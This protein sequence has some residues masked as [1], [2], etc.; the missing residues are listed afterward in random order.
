MNINTQ[1]QNKISQIIFEEDFK[2]IVT[3]TVNKLNN[4]Y[5]NPNP[6]PDYLDAEFIEF[7]FGQDKM[8]PHDKDTIRPIHYLFLKMSPDLFKKIAKLNLPWNQLT[9]NGSHLLNCMFANP[10]L[11]NITDISEWINTHSIDWVELNRSNWFLDN[12]IK[13]L[14][15]YHVSEQVQLA[16]Y[17]YFYSENKD[18]LDRSIGLMVCYSHSSVVARAIADGANL[19]QT[20]GVLNNSLLHL[21]FFKEKI[22]END[23]KIADMLIDSGLGLN[24]NNLNKY[25]PFEYL[26]ANNNSKWILHFLRKGGDPNV[27]CESDGNILVTFIKQKCSIETFKELVKLGCNYKYVDDHNFSLLHWATYLDLLDHIKYLFSLGLTN[28]CAIPKGAHDYYPKGLTP[29]HHVFLFGSEAT[30]HWVMDN[31]PNLLTSKWQEVNGSWI[32]PAHEYLSANTR[33]SKLQKMA[34]IGKFCLI[35]K[36]KHYADK[37]FK[38]FC[39]SISYQVPSSE[40]LDN[41]DKPCLLFKYFVTGQNP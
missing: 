6:D 23:L 39:D 41:P 40:Y 14:G 25:T 2:N 7:I 9:Q 29:L 34:L 18:L 24:K 10:Y 1:I 17:D 12:V 4:F 22:T 5:S 11:F 3:M 26:V 36:Q 30:C 32:K 15:H 19:K 20:Y 38:W 21:V 28:F 33:L 35:V 16:W 31:A 27:S 8:F 13:T 37:P